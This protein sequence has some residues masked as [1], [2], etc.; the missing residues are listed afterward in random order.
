MLPDFEM[1]V[2]RF[3]ERPD[4]TI[5]PVSDVHLGAAEHMEKEWAA[6][7]ESVLSRPNVY[8]VTFTV[9]SSGAGD[10]GSGSPSK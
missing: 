6:F 8:P 4:L 1:I 7:C 5:I 3:E 2:H 10:S 9:L